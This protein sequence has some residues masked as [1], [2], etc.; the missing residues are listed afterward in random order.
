MSRKKLMKMEYIDIQ[1]DEK[2]KKL[3]NKISFKNNQEL[4]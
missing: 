2:T 1:E 4:E 3:P